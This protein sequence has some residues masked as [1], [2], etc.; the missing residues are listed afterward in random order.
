M[1]LQAA[2]SHDCSHNTIS[3]T[4]LQSYGSRFRVCMK[5][6]LETH[7]TRDTPIFFIIDAALTNQ[8][9]PEWS[10]ILEG[11]LHARRKDIGIL[12]QNSHGAP[13]HP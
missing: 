9:Q 3:D 7:K 1:R 8:H 13:E 11:F 10:D 12:I 6:N 2:I 5:R 4:I